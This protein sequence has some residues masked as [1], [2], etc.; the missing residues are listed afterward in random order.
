MEESVKYQAAT[1]ELEYKM[2]LFDFY[3]RL[4][5]K[6]GKSDTEILQLFPEMKVFI[7]N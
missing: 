3:D 4:R 2:K 5:N 6:N 7:E 1:V